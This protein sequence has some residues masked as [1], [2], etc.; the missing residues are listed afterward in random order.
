MSVAGEKLCAWAGGSKGGHSSNIA[1]PFRSPQASLVPSVDSIKG[2]LMRSLSS[3]AFPLVVF[4]AM[5]CSP[6]SGEGSS[7]KATVEL[8]PQTVSSLEGDFLYHVVMLRAA[9]G[10]LLDLI[11]LL[12]EERDLLRD[13]GEPLPYWMRHTQGD[14]WDLLLLYPMENFHDY[15]EPQRTLRRLESGTQKGLSEEQL[16]LEA[17]RITSWRDEMFVRGPAPEVVDSAFQENAF[18]HVEMFVALAGRQRELLEERRMENHYLRELDRPQNLIFVREAGG[19]W[20]SFTLGF[21]RDLKHYS[22]SADIPA[23]AEDLAA[24]SAGFEGSDR[25]GSYLRRLIL[26][27]RDTLCVAIN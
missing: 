24:K 22:E 8:E 11:E 25:I 15:F 7:A 27:H 3:V 1:N 12:K 6:T 23:E 5:A 10:R 16:K 21:Y 20:D 26:Y 18:Y 17:D 4:L 13:A 14:Q 9:P 19:P 2:L